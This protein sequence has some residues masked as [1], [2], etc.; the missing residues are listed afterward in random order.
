MAEKHYV[1]KDGDWDKANNWSATRGGAGGAGVPEADD[2]VF[3]ENL[4]HLLATGTSQGSIDL[5][6]LYATIVQGG[7]LGSDSTPLAIAVSNETTATPNAV[8]RNYGG[9]PVYLTAGTNGIDSL[10]IVGFSEFVLSGTFVNIYAG[11]SGTARL[12]DGFA[13]TALNTAGMGTILEAGS[14]TVAAIVA[15]AGSHRLDRSVTTLSL[16]GR[17][18]AVSRKTAAFT[19]IN[20]FPS[21]AGQR[22]TTYTHQSSGTIGTINVYTDA[23]ASA[24]G[25]TAPFTVTNS[26]LYAGGRLFEDAAEGLITYTNPTVR[27]GF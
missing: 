13:V 22:G 18:R 8:I 21:N 24:A 14:G 1:G 26:T 15:Q 5:Q 3:V 19:T 2:E 12:A 17:A 27:R 20:L 10:T 6:S 25:A 9:A 16:Y 23:A 7:Q 11:V 4:N